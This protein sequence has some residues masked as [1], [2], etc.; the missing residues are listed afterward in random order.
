MTSANT[1]HWHTQLCRSAADGDDNDM[2]EY[3]PNFEKDD[4]GD[5]EFDF[6]FEE[7]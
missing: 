3:P 6:M 2:E 7:D 5:E 4:N 1:M